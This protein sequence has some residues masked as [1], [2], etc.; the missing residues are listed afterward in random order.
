MLIRTDTP[1]KNE[2][3]NSK[4][5]KVVAANGG[6][7]ELGHLIGASRLSVSNVLPERELSV[8]AVMKAASAI[9]WPEPSYEQ[10]TQFDDMERARARTFTLPT[11]V[12]VRNRGDT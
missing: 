9:L 12:Q 3:D 2:R 4:P 10:P 11:R 8:E 5:R 7:L 6:A 1:P